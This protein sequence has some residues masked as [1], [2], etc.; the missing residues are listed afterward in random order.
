MKL[1]TLFQLNF[2][3]NARELTLL[4]N[5]DDRIKTFGLKAYMNECV[6]T[7][8][9]MSGRRQEFIKYAEEDDRIVMQFTDFILDSDNI[10]THLDTQVLELIYKSFIAYEEYMAVEENTAADLPNVTNTGE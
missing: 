3:L 4:S 6:N 2:D 9:V 8:I 1:S 7:A 5:A 10:N